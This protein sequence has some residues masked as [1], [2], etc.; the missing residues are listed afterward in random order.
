MESQG[1]QSH[2]VLITV[3]KRNFRKAIDRNLLKRR[4]RESFRLN[5]YRLSHFENGFLL[6]AYIY[7]GKV[8]ADYS[9]I[10]NKLIKTLLRLNSSTENTSSDENIQ[11]GL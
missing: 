7:T 4:I 5:K 9:E 2:K 10:D 8:I 11:K 6:I 3:P 1:D